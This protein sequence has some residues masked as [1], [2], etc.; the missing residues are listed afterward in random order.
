[1]ITVKIYDPCPNLKHIFV[2]IPI[3]GNASFTLYFGAFTS[4]F[5]VE[6]LPYNLLHIGLQVSVRRFPSLVFSRPP[7]FCSTPTLTWVK[8]GWG[9]WS[10]IAS[11]N[12]K[13]SYCILKKFNSPMVI[14]PSLGSDIQISWQVVAGKI[15]THEFQVK[16]FAH[17]KLFLYMLMESV[18]GFFDRWITM[19][20]QCIWSRR[21]RAALFLGISHLMS[22]NGII[23][24][25]S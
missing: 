18:C 7:S 8:R 10:I 2:R 21:N 4:L 15:W 20:W 14:C 11:K 9:Q 16:A 3:A 13:S 1:M 5:R 6:S 24:W 22:S 25:I 17:Y 19:L 23:C 12:K